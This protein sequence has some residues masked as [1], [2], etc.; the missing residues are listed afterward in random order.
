MLS[1]GVGRKRS[2]EGAATTAAAAGTYDDVSPF[3]RACH[4]TPV[5]PLFISEIPR[6]KNRRRNRIESDSESDSNVGEV[7][8][9]EAMVHRPAAA[10]AATVAA[11][12]SPLM[13]PKQN[14][15]WSDQEIDEILK[16]LLFLLDNPPEKVVGPWKSRNF[17]IFLVDRLKNEHRILQCR[18]AQA[19]RSKLFHIFGETE[20][21][22][23]N[24]DFLEEKVGALIEKYNSKKT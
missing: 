20:N 13:S 18:S 1:K 9:V 11:A 19:L 8:I 5:S 23:I 10:A 24:R 15:R 21:F 3:V 2:R 14:P 17:S 22:L 7:H 16:D 6:T 12:A 4:E